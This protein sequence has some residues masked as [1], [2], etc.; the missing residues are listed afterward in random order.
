M[1]VSF[2]VFFDGFFWEIKYVIVEKGCVVF[3][4]EF[5]VFF[6]YVIELWKEFFCVVIGVEYYGD[7]VWRGDGMD[8][9]GGS[10]CVSNGGYKFLV[11]NII[12]NKRWGDLFL[13]FL[14]L[15][16]MFFLVK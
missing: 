6:E 13:C 9:V 12:R 15:F 2:N 11:L 3:F 14:E 4:E 16:L 8:V 10:Y 1:D 5:F 7:V